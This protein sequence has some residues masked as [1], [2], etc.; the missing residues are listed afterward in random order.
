MLDYF[1]FIANINADTEASTLIMQKFKVNLV[2]YLQD[3][4]V[5]G[6]IQAEGE[7]PVLQSA[8]QE[9]GVYTVA[10]AQCGAR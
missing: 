2:M 4:M 3:W 10:L 9:D 7:E 1:R 8:T 5:Q 6:H